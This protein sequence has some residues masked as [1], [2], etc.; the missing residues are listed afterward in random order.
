MASLFSRA[1]R[2]R[3]KRGEADR[4][5]DDIHSRYIEAEIDGL[6]VGCLYLPNGNPALGPKFDYK[7]LAGALDETF[8]IADRH[9]DA[10]RLYAVNPDGTMKWKFTTGVI[11]DIDSSPAIGTDGTVYFGSDDGNLYAVGDAVGSRPPH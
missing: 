3:E 4:A 2:I 8:G 9:Q 10:H 11:Q 5:I 6:L 7:P 1:I